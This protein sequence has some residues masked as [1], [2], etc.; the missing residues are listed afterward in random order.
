MGPC[1]RSWWIKL[2]DG[3]TTLGLPIIN[4]T[5]SKS[6]VVPA[7]EKRLRRR[8]N[9]LNMLYPKDIVDSENAMWFTLN[10]EMF[11]PLVKVV[12][13]MQAAMR[14]TV[15][16]PRETYD[17]LVKVEIA[18]LRHVAS[19]ATDALVGSI[20]MFEAQAVGLMGAVGGMHERRKKTHLAALGR[21]PH[22]PL[23]NTGELS[24]LSQILDGFTD[25]LKRRVSEMTG[26]SGG[27]AEEIIVIW[28][29]VE[30][31]EAKLKVR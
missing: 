29:K 16:S 25:V 1:E 12:N 5:T 24:S 28:D 31:L 26:R 21:V 30:E 11:R 14:I 20:D 18:C 3:I 9:A 10:H 7:S 4:W 13:R 17:A 8:A 15:L 2:H 6:T 19:T 23:Y 27:K 22:H